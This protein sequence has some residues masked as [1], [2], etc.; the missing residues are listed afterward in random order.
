[1]EKQTKTNLGKEKEIRIELRSVSCPS[2][3]RNQDCGILVLVVFIGSLNYNENFVYYEDVLKYVSKTHKE[4]TGEDFK[5]EQ[6]GVDM[7][8]NVLAHFLPD[9]EVEFYNIITKSFGNTE[10]NVRILNR[11]AE[12]KAAYR[13]ALLSSWDHKNNTVGAGHY[14]ILNTTIGTQEEILEE[15]RAR[16]FEEGKTTIQSC[17]QCKKYPVFLR[18]EFNAYKTFCNKKCQSNFYKQ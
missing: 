7:I 13:L 8:E 18:E 5:D 11:G 15:L 6:I 12:K 9:Y 2:S 16:R 10:A 3:G 4:F 17:I 14:V 1:M